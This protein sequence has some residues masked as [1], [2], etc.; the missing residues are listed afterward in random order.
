MA[1]RRLSLL[2]LGLLA[3]LM[4]ASAARSEEPSRDRHSGY[5][6]PEPGT[7]ETYKARAQTLDEA[8][9]AVRIG[10]VTGLAN[11]I[12]AR[13]YAPTMAIFA[14]GAK[15]EKLILVSL[16]EGRVDTLFRARAVFANLTSVARVMPVFAEYG[17][18][19]VFTFFDLAKMLGFTQITITDG[20]DFAHQVFI[21]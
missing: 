19:N 12:L 18:Q 21:E 3:V 15:A 20:D 4:L 11:Q 1:H 6:Y 14:K 2:P 13:P 9:R 17:V 5:Y 8:G 10:F 7:K 16:Q